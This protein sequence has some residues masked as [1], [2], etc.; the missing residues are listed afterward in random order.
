MASMVYLLACEISKYLTIGFWTRVG[1]LQY[2]P[3]RTEAQNWKELK[4]TWYPLFHERNNTAED[5]QSNDIWAMTSQS[6]T[7]RGHY[8]FPRGPEVFC[9]SPLND[10]GDGSD[11]GH[12]FGDKLVLGT[13]P[14]SLWRYTHVYMVFR[15]NTEA[16]VYLILPL[17]LRL[18]G[19]RRNVLSRGL[20]LLHPPVSSSWPLWWNGEEEPLLAAHIHSPEMP[21]SGERQHREGPH[22]CSRDSPVELTPLPRNSPDSKKRSALFKRLT[23]CCYDGH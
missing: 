1:Y 19:G 3:V 18:G 6:L 17:M 8:Q 16:Y 7:K 20:S 5:L 12:R 4:I 14:L 22:S 15:L 10:E 9:P 11:P 23:G 21:R 2:T 13:L